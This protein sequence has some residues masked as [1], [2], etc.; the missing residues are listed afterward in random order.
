MSDTRTPDEIER[1]IEQDREA[2][3]STINTLQDTFS[4][5]N[6]VRSVTE[7]FRTHGGDMGRSISAA[8]RDNPLAL[9]V[10]GIGLGWLIFGNGPSA[11]RIEHGARA[12]GRSDDPDNH[13]R[14][15]GAQTPVRTGVTRARTYGEGAEA[16]MV[17]RGPRPQGSGPEWVSDANRGP[18]AAQRMRAGWTRVARSTGDAGRSAGAR[19]QAGGAAASSGAASVSSGASRMAGRVRDR[20]EDT[21]RRLS[22]G[23]ERMSEEARERIIAARERAI[24]ASERAGRNL[25]AGADRAQD[26]FE[27]HPIVAGALAFAVGAAIAGALPRT[28]TED[29]YF[30]EESDALYDEA[31]RVFREE[32]ARAGRVA[33]AALDE[34]RRV[35]EEAKGS[36][37]SAARD[38]KDRADNETPGDGSAADAAV[39]KVE[40]AA[41]R[42]ADAAEKQVDKETRDDRKV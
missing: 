17:A 30:G 36:M 38:L 12:V 15:H 41:R 5:D 42:V 3:T 11:G 40:D 24:E 20:S 7:T 37:D 6:I 21:A 22:E 34:A 25:Q 35:G 13:D 9:A 23:T 27:D 39:D 33:G 10:T 4:A 28:R 18:S 16:G 1:D 19:L 14:A 31:E 29:D 26:F 8:A 32:Q 2:L